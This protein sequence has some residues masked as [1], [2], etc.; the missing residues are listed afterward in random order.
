M[1]QPQQPE[2]K[3]AVAAGRLPDSTTSTVIG[4]TVTIKGKLRTKEDLIIKG[5]IE[6]DITSQ[7]ALFVENSG[8]IKANVDVRM[9]RISGV[10]VGDVTAHE[11]IE[12]APDGRVVGDL[13][14]PRI[15][16]SDGAAF[17]GKIDMPDAAE[18]K[19]RPKKPGKKPEVDGP[20]A[21]SLVG[22]GIHSP[23]DIPKA[24]EDRKGPHT[25][26]RPAGAWGRL[27]PSRER[28]SG[29]LLRA[30]PSDRR[31]PCSSWIL[32]SLR[33]PPRA[34]ARSPRPEAAYR[35]L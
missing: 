6:A 8:V 32:R 2:K 31:R 24:P 30:R 29:A 15:I 19:S 26:A 25:G 4:K 33:D 35:H 28:T 1:A 10:V 23:A 34:R 5:R 12:I 21:P 9:V 11:K 3:K 16:I 20:T 18:M 7:K 27:R 13:T 17:R 22:K 14:A